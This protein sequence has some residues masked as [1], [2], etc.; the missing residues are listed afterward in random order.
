MPR[1][2]RAPWIWLAAL[3]VWFGVL[4]WL[5][6]RPLT[7]PEGPEIPHFDKVAHFGYF[8]GGGGLLAAFLFRLRP[9]N[10]RWGRVIVL[11]AAILATLGAVDEWHQTFTPGRSGG[12]AGDWLADAAGGLCGALVFRRIHGSLR[13]R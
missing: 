12:D 7:L 13:W 3:A 9:E 10:P 8:F 1:L 2:P 6:S 11:T 4:W 5:S